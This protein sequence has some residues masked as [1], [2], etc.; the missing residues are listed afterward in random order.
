MKKK[1]KKNPALSPAALFFGLFLPAVLIAGFY[2]LRESTVLMSAWALGA[3]APLEQ[4]IGRFTGLLPFSLGEALGGC[5]LLGSLLWLLRA[6]LRAFTKREWHLLPRRL[7]GLLGLFAWLWCSLCWLW[8]AA[9]YTPGFAQRSGLVVRSYS[10][11]ELERLTR[12]FAREA[13]A[14]SAQVP[15]DAQGH[16]L[17][18][19][20]ALFRAGE[21]CYEALEREFP[22]LALSKRPAKPLLC[23]PLQSRLGFTGVY[24]PWTGEANVNVDSPACLCPATIAHEMAHQRMVASEAEANFVGIAACLSCQDIRF[25][26]SGYLMGLIELSNALYQRSPSAWRDILGASFTPELSQDW[27]DNYYYW[28]RMQSKVEDA[29]SETYDS[30]LKG[31]GQE[32]GMASYGACVDLLLSYYNASTR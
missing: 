14:R 4:T 17:R 22:F 8:N 20:T 9:Y 6:I 11:E 16:F 31:N 13:A 27:D 32:L 12:W 21:S 10:L 7:L 26:Y 2:L 24:L 15:R 19:N 30:F 23:S 28:Q 18:E 1:R 25:Q 29:A 5:L 3:A